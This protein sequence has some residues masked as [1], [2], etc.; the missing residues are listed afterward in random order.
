SGVTRGRAGGRRGPPVRGAGPAVASAGGAGGAR[1]YVGTLP[2]LV[3]EPGEPAVEERKPV[4]G[5]PPVSVEF[6]PPDDIRPGQVG[7]LIDES[8]DV[9]DVIATI[10]DLAVRKYL[11]IR[12]LRRQGATN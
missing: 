8:A 10:V 6:V 5:A 7:T 1:R 12:E 11:R 4:L 2:G 9:I 3:P